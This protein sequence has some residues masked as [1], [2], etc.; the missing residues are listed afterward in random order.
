MLYQYRPFLYLFVNS[1]QHFWLPKYV[2]FLN[3]SLNHVK[4]LFASLINELN[5]IFETYSFYI[6]MK[7]MSLPLYKNYLL[8]NNNKNVWL[9]NLL[10]A[11]WIELSILHT[12]YFL[13]FTNTLF[14]H[15]DHV[16]EKETEALWGQVACPNSRSPPDP[17]QFL[18]ALI[19]CLRNWSILTAK[20]NRGLN[21]K[22]KNLYVLFI[23]IN[24]T[25]NRMPVNIFMLF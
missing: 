16:T 12:L 7:V 11:W 1:F 24:D 3:S 8:T 13:I 15:H 2:C 5:K 19:Y 10:C 25:Y 22:T 9:K 4:H 6:C 17:T 14:E 18:S 21:N 23:F 20:F